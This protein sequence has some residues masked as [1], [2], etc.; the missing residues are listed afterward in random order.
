MVFFVQEDAFVNADVI[1]SQRPIKVLIVDDTRTIRSLIR[2][3]LARDPRVEVVGE[4]GDPYQARALIK[5]LRPDV[6]TLDVEMPRMNGLVFL[7]KIMRLRPMP[8]IM[9]ST[10]TV[11]QSDA[12]VRA[13]ALG[14]LECIDLKLLQRGDPRVAKL[15]D[16]VVM[17]G[18]ANVRKCSEVAPS[19]EAPVGAEAFEW[20]GR[21]VFI[22]SSTGGVDA[23]MQVFADFP[24]NCPPT[25]VAQH[26]PAPFLQS[27]ARRLDTHC[28]PDVRLA[29]GGEI[30]KQGQILL[31]AGGDQ[32]VRI[33]RAEPL[34]VAGVPDDG[35][36]LYVPSVSVLFQYSRILFQFYREISR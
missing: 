17:A 19:G 30:L 24:A 1:N 25:L 26:M 15:S 28:A 27:F 21:S 31:A 34:T 5:A 8:V 23:L 36:A 35:S 10:R 13:L 7:E 32:H 6:L 29:H 12:A 16:T 18:N 22:G 4:A 3:L 14:A 9:V 11:E 2:A 20:N 33:R